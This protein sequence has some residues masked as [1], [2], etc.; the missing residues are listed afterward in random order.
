MCKHTASL[1]PD[2]KEIRSLAVEIS[3][4]KDLEESAVDITLSHLSNLREI[5]FV[6]GHEMRLLEFKYTEYIRFSEQEAMEPFLWR[7][8][9]G[10][11]ERIDVFKRCV[12]QVIEA[13]IV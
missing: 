4:Q 6:V 3:S 10:W 9:K 5:I 2:I 8:W 13:K 11:I 1:Y 7:R 12:V